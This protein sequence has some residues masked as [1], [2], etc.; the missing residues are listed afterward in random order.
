MNIH[1]MI[2]DDYDRIY[3]LWIS[4]P[5]MRVSDIDDSKAGIEKYIDRNPNT[6]F[7]AEKDGEIIGVL[8]TAK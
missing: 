1:K 5:G 4:A 7:V 6:C 2:I 8:F 3:S